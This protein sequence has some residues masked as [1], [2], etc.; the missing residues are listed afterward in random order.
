MK[1]KKLVFEVIGA[2]ILIPML[3]GFLIYD[4]AWAMVL[5]PA[6]IIVSYRWLKRRKRQK[7]R[8]RVNR[9]FEIAMQSISGDLKSGMSMDNAWKSA[10]KVL[11]ESREKETEAGELEGLMTE[12][13]H[14]MEM[15]EPLE[16]LLPELAMQTGD[17]DIENFAEVYSYAKK[18][19]GNLA[20]IVERTE[21]MMRD[22]RETEQDIQV[23]I[24]SKR[25]EQRVM[26]GMPVFILL[27]LRLSAPEYLQSLYHNLFGQIVM[28]IGVALYIGIIVLSNRVMRIE[29]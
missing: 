13:C 14:S 3:L 18:S 2:G 10:V 25:L 19:G 11:K 21:L 26:N 12:I 5:V 24:A 22:K 29:V 7:N 17:E 20:G 9:D 28:T 1:D 27:F 8:E 23:L 6:V 15:N 4:S 16:E